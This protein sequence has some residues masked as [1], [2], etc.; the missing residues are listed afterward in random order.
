MI[1]MLS[2]AWS[3][4]TGRIGASTPADSPKTISHRIQWNK[5]FSFGGDDPNVSV[6]KRNV[7][8]ILWDGKKIGST[9]KALVFFKSLKPDASWEVI[10]DMPDSPGAEGGRKPNPMGRAFLQ[11]CGFIEDWLGFGVS[12]KFERR[13]V[14]VTTHFLMIG[15]PIDHST[16]A[17]WDTPVWYFDQK[18]H[19]NGAAVAKAMK[20]IRWDKGDMLR[21]LISPYPTFDV[22]GRPDANSEIQRQLGELQRIRKVQLIGINATMLHW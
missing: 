9:D 8:E 3:D 11:D 22:V 17:N 6:S 1:G 18:K 13:G 20:D 7:L 16:G 15:G 21:I 5:W 4:D 2:L 19:E 10:F 14:A 12:L